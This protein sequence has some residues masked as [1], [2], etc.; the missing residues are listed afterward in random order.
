LEVKLTTKDDLLSEI[1]DIMNYLQMSSIATRAS[2]LISSDSLE[3]EFS[4]LVSRLNIIKE[5]VLDIKELEYDAD[6][7]DQ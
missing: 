4:Y 1:E 6:I 7:Q 3:E 5:K 2:C